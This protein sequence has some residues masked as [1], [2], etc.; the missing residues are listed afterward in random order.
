VARPRLG[1]DCWFLAGPTAA[2]KTS[3]ALRLAERLDAEFRAK[4]L[5]LGAS[6]RHEDRWIFLLARGLLAHD[7]LLHGMQA[8]VAKA[9]VAPATIAGL[10]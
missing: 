5:E 2:G 8:M 3:L 10:P 7:G 1:G 6:R 9:I 4:P